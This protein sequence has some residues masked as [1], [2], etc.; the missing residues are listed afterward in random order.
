M[1]KMPSVYTCILLPLLTLK[2]LSQ[3]HEVLQQENLVSIRSMEFGRDCSLYAVYHKRVRYT[4]LRTAIR[5]FFHVIN[6]R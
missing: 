3:T 1:K 2:Y 5:V 6:N 4:F